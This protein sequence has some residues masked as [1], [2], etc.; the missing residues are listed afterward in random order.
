RDRDER[1]VRREGEAARRRGGRPGGR[2]APRHLPG[3]VRGRPRAAQ[4]AEEGGLPH[5]G[6][7]DQGKEEV[8]PEGRAPSLPVQQALRR[9]VSERRLSSADEPRLIRGE[10]LDE[11]AAAART[12][13]YD[14]SLPRVGRPE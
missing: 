14:T 4:A 7:P 13:I 5:A 10:S 1:E 8:R 9:C 3:P 6:R 11:A 12:L 2:A